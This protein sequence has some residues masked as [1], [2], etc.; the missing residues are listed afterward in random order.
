MFIGAQLFCYLL[1]DLKFLMARELSSLIYVG[2][3]NP[4]LIAF[5]N[6]V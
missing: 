1:V 6:I 4:E 2:K 5:E 3:M